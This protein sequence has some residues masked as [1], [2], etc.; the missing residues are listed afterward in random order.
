MLKMEPEVS[1]RFKYASV[2][3]DVVLTIRSQDEYPSGTGCTFS[4]LTPVELPTAA[5]LRSVTA[6]N[7]RCSSDS[8]TKSRR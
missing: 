1:S 5:Q 4:W 3:S 8:N 7:R 2:Q 6:S